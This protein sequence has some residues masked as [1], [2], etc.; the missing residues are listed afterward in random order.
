MNKINISTNITYDP[1]QLFLDLVGSTWILDSLFLFVLTPLGLISF[2][3]NFIS[4]MVFFQKEFNKIIIFS[5]LKGI[6]RFLR[7]LV[8]YF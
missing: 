4:F 5:Y 8:N 1:Y 7:F 6:L 3:S 2:L